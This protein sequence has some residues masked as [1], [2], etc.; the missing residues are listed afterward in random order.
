MCWSILEFCMGFL[1]LI[2]NLISTTSALVSS[3]ACRNCRRSFRVSSLIYLFVFGSD[4]NSSSYLAFC[5]ISIARNFSHVFA[6]LKNLLKL[7]LTNLCLFILCQ[8][9]ESIS[10]CSFG[11]FIWFWALWIW[12]S[13][14]MYM[15]FSLVCIWHSLLNCFCVTIYRWKMKV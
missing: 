14:G 1:Y 6:I 4:V 10:G 7:L 3:A 8:V 12:F 2:T 9:L 5:Q 15:A 13:S 11:R